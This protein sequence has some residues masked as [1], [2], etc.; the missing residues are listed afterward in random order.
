M[1]KEVSG[2]QGQGAEIIV[3]DATIDDRDFVINAARRLASFELP[4][5]RTANEIVTREQKDLQEFFERRVEGS[6]LLIAGGTGEQRLGYVYLETK[7]DHFSGRQC[8]HI[9]TIAVSESYEGRGV[10]SVL[11]RAAEEWARS[12][13]YSQLTLNVFARND[14]ARET[15]EHLGFR[16]ETLHY[17]KRLDESG[18]SQT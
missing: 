9:N 5:W 10:G 18:P 8:G 6:A 17:V 4:P 1:S 15:Y 11:M 3:R 14:H 16:A 12:K 13:G 7:Q 2:I